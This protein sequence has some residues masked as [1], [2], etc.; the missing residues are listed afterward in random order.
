[1]LL[2]IQHISTY[3]LKI[4]ENSFF[5]KNLPSN[6]PNDEAQAEM[7]LYL[8]EFLKNNDFE[9]YEISNFAK[10]GYYSRHN[11]SY[12]K[13]KEYYGFGL[14]ASGYVDKVRY[15]NI[16]DFTQYLE[17]PTQREEEDFINIDEKLENEI[18]LALRLQ[19]GVDIVEINSKYNIDFEKKYKKIIEK[20]AEPNLLE[21]IDNH[22][23][24][25]EK[26]ILLSNDIMSEFLD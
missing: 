8:C 9:H 23:K 18:F 16:S 13:N 4:E 12:W 11:C 15:K 22:C 1:M 10:K 25:T 26:G 7:F 6:L 19:E 5:G 24:L 2:D 20:Y 3:G 21:I 14:N 17:N